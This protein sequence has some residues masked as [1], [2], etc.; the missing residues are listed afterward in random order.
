MSSAS[1]VITEVL[2]TIAS[3]NPE[4]AAT[5]GDYIQD[6]EAQVSAAKALVGLTLAPGQEIVTGGAPCPKP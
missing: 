5:L 2:A 4:A 6:L 3:T 1:P